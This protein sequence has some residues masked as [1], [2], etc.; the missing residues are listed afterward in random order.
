MSFKNVRTRFGS[1]S[2]W[3]DLWLF[4]NYKRLYYLHTYK[5]T[6]NC[7][8]IYTYFCEIIKIHCIIKPH[9]WNLDQVKCGLS[10]DNFWSHFGPKEMKDTIIITVIVKQHNQ[11]ANQPTTQPNL[12]MKMKWENQYGPRC[13]HMHAHSLSDKA[14]TPRASK[15]RQK[16]KNVWST[17]GNAFLNNIH[18]NK[19][20]ANRQTPLNWNRRK[21][22][23]WQ[24]QQL[25]K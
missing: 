16:G 12:Q 24:Q 11:L 22:V 5:C 21:C 2:I 15:F 7:I 9:N 19:Q 1:Q 17:C 14:F 8:L 18:Y 25:R 3:G 4:C 20:N 23:C 13:R 6:Y 10:H